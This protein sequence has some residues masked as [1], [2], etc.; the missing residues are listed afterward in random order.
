MDR[1]DNK[2]VRQQIKDKYKGRCAY[3][4]VD[5]TKQMQIDHIIPLKRCMGLTHKHQCELNKVENYN[6]SCSLC[7]AKKKTFSINDFKDDIIDDIRKLSE[8]NPKFKLLLRLGLIKI[9]KL[10]YDKI[11]YFERLGGRK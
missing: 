1:L 10:Q 3:C 7:N 9:S 6:P 4:G 8:Y 5:I 2:K 11:L